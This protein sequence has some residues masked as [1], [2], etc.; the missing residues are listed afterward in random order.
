[1]HLKPSALAL[2]VVF[3]FS[4]AA[5][6]VSVGQLVSKCG[7]DSK[8]YCKG[9]GYGDP[10]QICLDANYKKLAPKCQAIMDRLRDGEYVTLF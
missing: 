6:A 5:H 9:V 1:M 2:C 3:A 7:D 8:V 10:M 4:S